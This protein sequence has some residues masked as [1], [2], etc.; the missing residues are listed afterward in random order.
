MSLRF[1]PPRSPSSRRAELTRGFCFCY[2]ATWAPVVCRTAGFRDTRVGSVNG[3][4]SRCVYPRRNSSAT[5][6][7]PTVG[8]IPSPFAVS[9]QSGRS[10]RSCSSV[11]A[12]VSRYPLVSPLSRVLAF[13]SSLSSSVATEVAAFSAETSLS[14]TPR[15]SF[16]K[17][18]SF[19][20]ACCPDTF[21]F[22]LRPGTNVAAI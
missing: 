18:A 9:C 6:R 19:R 4:A 14:R 22:E 2:L 3:C 1:P 7:A 8:T 12:Y 10:R 20:Q 5:Y 13:V 11:S 17:R 15:C 21:V 16:G